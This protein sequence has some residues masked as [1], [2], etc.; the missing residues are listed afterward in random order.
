MARDCA[1]GERD[2]TGARCKASGPNHHPPDQRAAQ[3][4][5]AMKGMLAWIIGI[6]IPIIIILYLLD[7]F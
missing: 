3:G 5:D 1:W 2:Q 6:P 7:V 4:D